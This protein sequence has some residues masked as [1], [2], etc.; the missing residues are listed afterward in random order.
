M[1]VYFSKTSSFLKQTGSGHVNNDRKKK[2]KTRAVRSYVTT[3]SD[4]NK[5]S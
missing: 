3:F 2:K 5:L 1:I 4:K